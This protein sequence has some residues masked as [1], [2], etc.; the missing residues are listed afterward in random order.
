[1][2]FDL[3]ILSL[4]LLELS[5]FMDVYAHRRDPEY[6]DPTPAA[7]AEFAAETTCNFLEIGSTN[8]PD[9]RARDPSQGELGDENLR[10]WITVRHLY[11]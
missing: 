10:E 8:T 7:K 5:L 3:Q 6:G 9:D 4:F 1:M 2:H 11:L